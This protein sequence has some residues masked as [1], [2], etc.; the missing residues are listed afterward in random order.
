MPFIRVSVSGPTLTPQHIERLQTGV[1]DLMVSSLGK[2]RELT[3][4]LIE[5]PQGGGW[6]I[7][8]APMGVAAHLNAKITRGT[9]STAEK[10]RFVAEAMALLRT[11]VGDALDD[12]T[13]VV[14][15][16]I[17]GDAWGYGGQ[18]QDHRQEF[19]A[20]AAAAPSG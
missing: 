12:R 8:G 1:T 3:S 5:Q 4:V 2:R 16:E 10:A 15:D 18:T 14:V 20:A 11:V 17:T 7:G 6:S 9:N 13:Y 19:A